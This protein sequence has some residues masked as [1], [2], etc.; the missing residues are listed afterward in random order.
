MIK[1]TTNTEGLAKGLGTTSKSF[2]DFCTKL[3][4]GNIVLKEGQ[5]Y[6]QAYRKQLNTTTF[7]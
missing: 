1:T 6:L 3:K 2:I 5:T 7:S 4:N